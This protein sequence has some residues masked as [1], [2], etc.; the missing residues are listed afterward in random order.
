MKPTG[1][2]RKLD[3]LGRLVLPIE[4]RRKLEIA[5]KD[6]LEICVDGDTVVL[7]KADPRCAFC[8]NPDGLNC[9][10]GKLVCGDCIREFKC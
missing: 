10:K 8:G 6:E 2:V 7:R 1:H 9:F 3:E 5:E 4:V